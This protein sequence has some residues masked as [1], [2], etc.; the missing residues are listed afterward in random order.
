[1]K[2]FRI[3]RPRL[4]LAT[5]AAAVSA[6]CVPQAAAP[7]IPA[8]RTGPSAP[9]GDEL[10]VPETAGSMLREAPDDVVSPSFVK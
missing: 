8:F 10:V 7:R 1:M 4:F 9:F 3:S 6:G 5:V 2:Q